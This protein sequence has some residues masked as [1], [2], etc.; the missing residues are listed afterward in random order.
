VEL[1]GKK[2]VFQFQMQ[3]PERRSITRS[4]ERTRASSVYV[5]GK[6]KNKDLK[7]GVGTYTVKAKAVE[8]GYTDSA[9]ARADFTITK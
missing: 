7:L 9:I 1:L 8:A 5:V 3:K 4:M 6:K 2:L